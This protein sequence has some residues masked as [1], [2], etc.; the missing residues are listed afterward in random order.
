[1][2]MILLLHTGDDIPGIQQLKT[3]LNHKFDTKEE[4]GW[5]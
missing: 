2:L 5:G 3:F 4:S 1:M